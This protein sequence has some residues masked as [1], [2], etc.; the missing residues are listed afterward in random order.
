MET[1]YEQEDVIGLQRVSHE[2]AAFGLRYFSKLHRAARIADAEELFRSRWRDCVIAGAFRKE[3]RVLI[4]TEMIP[5]CLVFG[6]RVQ[7]Y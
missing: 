4:S 7:K 2:L 3:V 1:T 6:I 5:K